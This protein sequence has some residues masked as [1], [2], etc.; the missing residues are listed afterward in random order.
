MY[1]GQL[2]RTHRLVTETREYTACWTPE[3]SRQNTCFKKYRMRGPQSVL[4]SLRKAVKEDGERGAMAGTHISL[5][6]VQWDAWHPQEN[7]VSEVAH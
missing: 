5:L 1:E 2:S 6:S 7:G 4:I 3:L